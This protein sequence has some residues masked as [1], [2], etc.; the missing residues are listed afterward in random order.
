M[1]LI[2]FQYQVLFIQLF[3]VRLPNLTAA[4]KGQPGRSLYATQLEPQCWYTA[5]AGAQYIF[6]E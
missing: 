1:A 6:D 3:I 4:Q 5:A 2:Q